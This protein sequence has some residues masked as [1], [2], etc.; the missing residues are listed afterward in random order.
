MDAGDIG[1]Q[2]AA[3]T[4]FWSQRIVGEANGSMTA[5]IHAPRLACP[6]KPAGAAT[7]T[8]VLGCSW[9]AGEDDD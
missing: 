6:P 5:Q 4:E 8:T 9:K 2:A 7:F 3:L 1:K